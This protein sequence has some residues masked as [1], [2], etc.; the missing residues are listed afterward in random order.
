MRLKK[1]LNRLRYYCSWKYPT[2]YSYWRKSIFPAQLAILCLVLF[3][4]V[5][6]Y[7]DNYSFAAAM[8]VAQPHTTVSPQTERSKRLLYAPPNKINTPKSSVVETVATVAPSETVTWKPSIHPQAEAQV[9]KYQALRAEASA[10]RGSTNDSAPATAEVLKPTAA[11]RLPISIPASSTEK[12]AL[13]QKA[14]T[15]EV[16]RAEEILKEKKR[17]AQLLELK[18]QDAKAL[19]VTEKHRSERLPIVTDKWLHSQNP[20][21]F[22]IQVASSTDYQGLLTYAHDKKLN[23]PIAIYPFKKSREGKVVYGVSTGLYSSSKEAMN[24]AS[25]LS[26]TKEHGVWIR[27]VAD[28]RAQMTTL[29]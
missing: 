9:K 28:L 17:Q 22:V 4:A 1:R 16:W 15:E 5:N 20:K 24:N 10:F 7:N 13:N 19:L 29:R 11:E 3:G 8:K 2:L 25:S 23:K 6:Y 14:L 18:I 26:N 12:I 21:M 27:K